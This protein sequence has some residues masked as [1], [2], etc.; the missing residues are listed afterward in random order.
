LPALRTARASSC[1]FPPRV[2]SRLLPYVVEGKPRGSPNLS[3]AKNT[4]TGS[5]AGSLRRVRTSL[6]EARS[7][8][9]R[10]KCVAVFSELPMGRAIWGR[11]SDAAYQVSEEPFKRRVHCI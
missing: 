8:N 10:E 1:Y 6:S 11:Q 4:A 5:I 3:L 7:L 2:K 9:S